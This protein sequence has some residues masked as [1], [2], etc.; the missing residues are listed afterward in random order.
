MSETLTATTILNTVSWAYACQLQVNLTK[1]YI[2]YSLFGIIMIRQESLFRRIHKVLL[3]VKLQIHK[4]VSS[5]HILSLKYSVV[6]ERKVRKEE[7]S[8]ATI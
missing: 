6:L 8:Q 1:N 2:S 4:I 3:H 7:W 5:S